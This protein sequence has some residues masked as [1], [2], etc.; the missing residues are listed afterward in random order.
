MARIMV[1]DDN[2]ATSEELV[3]ALLAAGHQAET[4]RHT[5]DALREVADGRFDLLVLALDS[6]GF[7]RTGA[8]EAI[9]HLAPQV[10]LI[11]IHRKP[12]EV[13]RT[14]AQT[15]VAA[16]LP[17]TTSIN[18]FMY[19]VTRSLEEKQPHTRLASF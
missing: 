14:A 4:C 3:N 10:K 11:A 8:L 13:L 1:C 7:S 19:A 17:R 9:N 16:V 5:M 18:A 6:A 12:A 15:G 2:A